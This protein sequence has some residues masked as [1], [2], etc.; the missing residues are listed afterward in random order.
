MNH[1]TN[2]K[3]IK[4]TKEES[5]FLTDNEVCRVSTCHNDIPHVVPVKKR[6]NLSNMLKILKSL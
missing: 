3:Q 5:E 2:K 4:F 1:I 6:R